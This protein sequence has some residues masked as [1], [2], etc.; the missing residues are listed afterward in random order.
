MLRGEGGRIKIILR[1]GGPN[2]SFRV[3]IDHLHQSGNAVVNFCAPKG[4]GISIM[5]Q[6]VLLVDSHTKV[7]IQETPD[8][9]SESV[10]CA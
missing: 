9:V 3:V 6:G 8:I 10:I 5:V 4:A 1:Q 2:F 7:V